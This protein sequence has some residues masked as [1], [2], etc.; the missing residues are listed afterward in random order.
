[1]RLTRTGLLLIA[2]SLFGE[3]QIVATTGTSHYGLNDTLSIDFTLTNTGDEAI[4]LTFLT[5]YFVGFYLG[6]WNSYQLPGYGTGEGQQLNIPPDSSVRYSLQHDLGEYPLR[7]GRYSLV[8]YI[9]EHHFQFGTPIPIVIGDYEYVN[10]V[11]EFFPQSDSLVLTN[12]GC[13]SNRVFLSVDDLDATT[14]SISIRSDWEYVHFVLPGLFPWEGYWFPTV[15]FTVHNENQQYDF[16]VY[17]DHAGVHE[18]LLLNDWTYSW[19]S[20]LTSFNLVLIDTNGTRVDTLS[21]PFYE[22]CS[23]GVVGTEVPQSFQLKTFPNPFNA[24]LR[25]DYTLETHEIVSI[26][27]YDLKGRVVWSQS[28]RFQLSGEHHLHWNASN[29]IDSGVY[30]VQIESGGISQ[31]QKVLLLK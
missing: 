25:I 14:Q 4:G 23:A 17:I 16:E 11:V 20:G 21:Q 15:F 6:G 3:I 24:A 28:P 7:T 9:T 12:G 1:M 30:V 10:P 27:I 2:V 22:Y 26:K 13:A 19:F 31:S 18:E 29:E 8:P 5:N